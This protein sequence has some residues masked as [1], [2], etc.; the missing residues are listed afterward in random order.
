[1]NNKINSNL[2]LIK[3]LDR[4]NI[5][6]SKKEV[7]DDYVSRKILTRNQSA[8]MLKIILESKNLSSV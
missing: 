7:F 4:A 8:D 1:M 5:S 6:P 3:S 2:Y